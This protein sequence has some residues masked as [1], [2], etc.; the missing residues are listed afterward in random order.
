MWN[1]LKFLVSVRVTVDPL[2]LFKRGGQ[3][4]NVCFSVI[5]ICDRPWI[6]EC[7]WGPEFLV[8][9]SIWVPKIPRVIFPIFLRILACS[10]VLN[11]N[12]LQEP[13]IFLCIGNTNL[14]FLRKF[15]ILIWDSDFQDG[16]LKTRIQNPALQLFNPISKSVSEVKIIC[17]NNEFPQIS[18]KQSNFHWGF[19]ESAANSKIR[20]IPSVQ[21]E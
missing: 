18:L 11:Q 9:H 21:W 13:S 10:Y 20:T 1:C 8:F 7:E 12:F 2:Y 4:L 6:K 19:S 15:P 14:H 3:S 5:F 17:K 16:I